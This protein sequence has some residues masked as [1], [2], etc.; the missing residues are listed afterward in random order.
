MILVL[1]IT[2][3]ILAHSPMLSISPS[4]TFA[5]PLR[6]C[7]L[8]FAINLE[9]GERIE[10]QR[11]PDFMLEGLVSP[12][13][14]FGL[15]EGFAPQNGTGDTNVEAGLGRPSYRVGTKENDFG[16]VIWTGDEVRPY[17]VHVWGM[18]FTGTDKDFPLLRR[19]QFGDKAKGGC[20]KPSFEQ[21]K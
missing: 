10:V 15:Y 11:G 16:Y 12:T 6:Y 9:A 8:K 19:L 21:S 13:G 7:G 1:Q 14:G 4:Q 3:I 20:A 18:A 2:A 5:G 17:F